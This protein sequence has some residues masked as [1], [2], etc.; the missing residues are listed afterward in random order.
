MRVWDK[1]NHIQESDLIETFSAPSRESHVTA[2][3]R[4]LEPVHAS[5]ETSKDRR[6][7]EWN[8]VKL[9]EE[10]NRKSECIQRNI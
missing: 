3:T 5:L 9:E 1:W 8:S 6:D 2:Y 4:S 7:D 10:E